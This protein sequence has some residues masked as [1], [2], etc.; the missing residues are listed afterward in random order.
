[1]LLLAACASGAYA[2]VLPKP[3]EFYFDTDSAASR[4]TVVDPA[5]PDV[6]GALVRERDRG[7][8]QVEATAQLAHVAM[9]SDREEL[10]LS[11]YEQALADSQSNSILGRRLRWNYA[12]DLY[13]AGR[14]EQALTRFAE[15]ISSVRGHAW[16]PPTLALVLWRLDRRAESVRWYAAAVRTEP[17]LW[18]NPANY[19]QLLPE[20]RAQ[21]HALLAEVHA[22]WR[23]APPA[24]P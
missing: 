23:A 14:A 18:D 24:W 3:K 10:G 16:V 15:A 6:A 9:G 12:W 2:Q 5:T 7:R 22:A 11:L 21:D 17:T 8:R 1:M 20:W 13:R 4:I 19:P